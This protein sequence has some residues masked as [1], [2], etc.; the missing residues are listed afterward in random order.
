MTKSRLKRNFLLVSTLTRVEQT[1]STFLA[2]GWSRLTPSAII[3]RL[4]GWLGSGPGIR[5]SAR[6]IVGS[7]CGLL[8]GLA[9]RPGS[10][11]GSRFHWTRPNRARG[12]SGSRLGARSWRRPGG[13]S[14]GGPWCRRGRQGFAT[15]NISRTWTQASQNLATTLLYRCVNALSV[16]IT[17]PGNRGSWVWTALNV[18]R[19]WTQSCLYGSAVTCS[20]VSVDTRS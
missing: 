16:T 18:R 1:A 12:R 10:W 15:T 3:D 2:G 8:S 9:R 20:G 7:R 5:A 14:K 19:P 4:V 13:R 11:L 17:R 6:S